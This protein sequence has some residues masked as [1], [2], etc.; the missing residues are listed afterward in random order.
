MAENLFAYTE[1]SL[2]SWD[3]IKRA[4]PLTIFQIFSIPALLIEPAR[5]TILTKSSTL[6][7]NHL[8]N[9]EDFL[10]KLTNFILL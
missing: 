8:S 10:S 6:T 2:Y 4:A 3:P 7:A 1:I 9:Y 5:L